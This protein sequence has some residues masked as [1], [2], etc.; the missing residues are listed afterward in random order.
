MKKAGIKIVIIIIVV[1]VVAVVIHQIQ[2]HHQAHHILSM[3]RRGGTIPIDGTVV[4]PLGRPDQEAIVC[5]PPSEIR[6]S[7][8]AGEKFECLFLTKPALEMEEN[9][10]SALSNGVFSQSYIVA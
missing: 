10:Q 7:S 6:G 1:A 9:K 5:I 8:N 3:V 2:V 4:D